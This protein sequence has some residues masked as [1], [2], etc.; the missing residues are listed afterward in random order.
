MVCTLGLTTQV[1]RCVC[2]CVCVCAFLSLALSLTRLRSL[3]LSLSLAPSFSLSL[4]LSSLSLSLW[5]LPS[6][7]QHLEVRMPLLT[8]FFVF[9]VLNMQLLVFASPFLQ[10]R[11][12]R[13]R[14][15]LFCIFFFG[16]DRCYPRSVSSVIGAAHSLSPT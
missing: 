14:C 10:F 13:D 3:L 7:S 15:S 4:S 1:F 5:L 9:Q 11:V 16:S 12:V 6:L 2:V 8:V